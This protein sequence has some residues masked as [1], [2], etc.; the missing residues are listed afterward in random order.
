MKCEQ[1][2][3]SISITA[4]LCGKFSPQG[5][6]NSLDVFGRGLD[7]SPRLQRCDADI[8]L[9]FGGVQSGVKGTQNQNQR[10]RAQGKAVSVKRGVYTA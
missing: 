7:S 6:R 8:S 5:V 4:L 2:A 3:P 9:Y 1:H 10:L